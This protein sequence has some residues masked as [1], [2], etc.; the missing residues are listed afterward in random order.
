MATTVVNL[1]S[2]ISCTDDLEPTF[3]VAT[4]TAM[5]GQALWHRLSTPRGLL[6]YDPDYGVDL[7]DALLDASTPVSRFA[8][9]SAIAREVEKDERV[10]RAS[11]SVKFNA[12]TSTMSVKV[13]IDTAEGPF[14][15]V[16]EVSKVTVALLRF[17]QAA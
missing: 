17:D 14:A 5:L 10:L 16:L 4:G 7:R 15:L 12:S 13:S 2:D 6:F 11:A 9:Q 8:L 3:A 1:G